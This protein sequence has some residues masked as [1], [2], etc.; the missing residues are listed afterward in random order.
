MEIPFDKRIAQLYSNG[1]MLIDHLPGYKV[2]FQAL[3]KQIAQIIESGD[4]GRNI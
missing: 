4:G 2:K 1:Q 3:Y